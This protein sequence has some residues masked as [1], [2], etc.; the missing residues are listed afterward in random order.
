[1]SLTRADKE[2]RFHANT[3]HIFNSHLHRFSLTDY[4]SDK[5]KSPLFTSSSSGFKRPDAGSERDTSGAGLSIVKEIFM[6][7]GEAIFS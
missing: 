7:I 1:M 3:A 4:A 5:A 2:E 6:G